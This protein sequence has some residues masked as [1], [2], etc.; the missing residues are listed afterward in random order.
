MRKMSNYYC[1]P[2][3]LTYK[4]Q[5]MKQN[6]HIRA[7]RE[8]ADASVVVFNNKYYMFPSMSG[9]FFTSMNLV[10][11][12]FHS[13]LQKMPVLD[14]APDV[15]VINGYLY[16]CASRNR[17]NCSFYRTK[18]PENELFEELPGVF[19]FWDPNMFQDEDGRV[20]F[21]WGCSSKKPIYGV[22]MDPETMHPVTEPIELIHSVPAEN[23]F[24]R[25][26]EDHRWST[27][28][29]IRPYLEGAW[30]TKYKDTYY[31]QYAIPGT[32]FN[33]YADG[34]YQSQNPLGPF[35]RAENNP[36][37]YQP[38]GFINGAGHGSTMQ[39]LSGNWWHVSTG[40][41]SANSPYERR[42]CMWKA[43]FDE[44][45]ELFCDQRFGDWPICVEK[46]AWENPEWMLISYGKKVTASSGRMA[47]AVTD[48]NIRTWWKADEDQDKN[49]IEV[50]LEKSYDVRA[51]QINFADDVIY[52]DDNVQIE[53]TASLGN[54]SVNEKNEKGICFQKVGPDFRALEERVAYT[55]W[56]LE[57]SADGEHYFVIEDK[58]QAQTDWS[59]DFLVREDGIRCRYLKLTILEVPYKV[60]PCIS[61]LR[62]WGKTEGKCPEKIERIQT[63]WKSPLDLEV[64]WNDVSAVGYVVC[65]G[66]EPSKLYH[67]R[68]VYGKTET[69]IGAIIKNKLL[70]V[71]IDAFNECGVTKGDVSEKLF[72]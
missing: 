4:Y 8:A 9:G 63:L 52:V 11:W 49:W 60:S 39:D 62:V 70:Y 37:S 21:Y 29:E 15:R 67:S 66:Y 41:V 24:E 12:E 22:E 43:G 35:E 44:D 46:E 40:R 59:H 32:E 71:R 31:L 54:L 38:G 65:W 13:F 36:Y 48:E 50:D 55:R 42:V 10:E 16:F 64:C 69:E 33:I 7:Y 3:N 17:D 56:Y 61:G 68:M 18:D 2:L 47:G 58:S 26:C 34:V 30:M 25:P 20:Y 23:G 57:G 5:L 1:N 45:G 19:P 72:F 53:N 51:I 28:P 14:Y 6:G 27:N